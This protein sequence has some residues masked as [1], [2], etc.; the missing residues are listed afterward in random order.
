MYF[1]V[2]ATQSTASQKTK[3]HLLPFIF[4]K[5][6]AKKP[7]PSSNLG[8]STRRLPGS[9]DHRS[10]P[11][12]PAKASRTRRQTTP[13]SSSSITW[14]S[15]VCPTY[16]KALTAVILFHKDPFNFTQ[17]RETSGSQTS[18]DL[19]G[20]EVSKDHKSDLYDKCTSDQWLMSSHSK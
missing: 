5:D 9:Q 17:P 18:R 4:R 16:C 8:L 3:L 14:S 11:L 7:R 6:L 1:A 2:E 12:G 20:S 19:L 10:V 15:P 13:A